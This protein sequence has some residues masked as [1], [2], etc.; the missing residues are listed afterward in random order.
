MIEL[1]KPGF[2]TTVFLAHTGLGRRVIQLAPKDAFFSQGDPADSVFYL[3][4]G[5]AK[6]T[7]SQPGSRS[8]SIFGIGVDRKQAARCIFPQEK[9]TLHA[10]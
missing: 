6:V 3:Q 1:E 10:H 8:Y 4:D 2:D 5:S 9:G 7:V